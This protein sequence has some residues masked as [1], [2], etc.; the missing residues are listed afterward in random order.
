MPAG[1]GT[2]PYGTGSM[3]GRGLGRCAGYGAPGFEAAR[4]LYLGA[5]RC[6]RFGIE[7]RRPGRAFFGRGGITPFYSPTAEEQKQILRGEADMLQDQLESIKNRL[8]ELE[9]QA[10]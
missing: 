6:R 8:N 3:T 7:G 10:K 9:K 2:G 5:G 1:N 4:P